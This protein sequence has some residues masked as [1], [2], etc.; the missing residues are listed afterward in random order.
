VVLAI[1][2]AAVVVTIAGFHAVLAQNQVRLERLRERTTSAEARYEARRLENG[3]LNSPERITA[4]ARDM[5]LGPP[6]VVPVAIP[7]LGEVPKRGG[8]SSTLA[9]WAEVKRHLDA[10]P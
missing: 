5:G 1:A 9:D 7:L 4:R 2:T 6:T 10:S 8:T 3:R